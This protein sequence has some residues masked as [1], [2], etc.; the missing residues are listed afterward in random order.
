MRDALPRETW[1]PPVTGEET[2]PQGSRAPAWREGSGRAQP[3]RRPRSTRAL[4]ANIEAG[5]W[6]W[7]R[8]GRGGRRPRS[9][10][11]PPARGE[12]ESRRFPEG[13]RPCPQRRRPPPCPPPFPDLRGPLQHRKG[14]ACATGAAPAPAPLPVLAPEPVRSPL[15]RG[16]WARGRQSDRRSGVRRCAASWSHPSTRACLSPTRDRFPR[17]VAAGVR[18]HVPSPHQWGCPVR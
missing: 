5:D 1:P 9:W 6:L 10:R 18:V 11:R 2:V 16:C 14:A 12:G 17:A 13:A 4:Y 3:P 7:L 15:C 8:E